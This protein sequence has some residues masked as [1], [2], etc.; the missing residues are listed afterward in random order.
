MKIQTFLLL[1]IAFVLSNCQSPNEPTA[2]GV[3]PSTPYPNPPAEGFNAEDSD[4]RAMEIADSVMLAM[5]GRQSWDTT[6]YFHWNFFGMRTLLWDKQEGRAK[7]TMLQDSTQMVV[8]LETGEGEIYREGNKLTDETALREGLQQ[9]KSIWIND[10]YWLFMPFKLK[11]SGVTLKYLKA[12]TTQAGQA[13]DVLQLTFESVGDTPQNKYHVWVGKEDRLVRQWAYFSN[14]TDE[15]PKFI[16]PW[17]D[18]QTYGDIMLSGDRG[19]RQ[20]TDIKVMEEVPR[21]AFAVN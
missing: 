15:E 17:D 2:A 10:A 5:G 18:Y 13:A 6:R 7:I 11:D 3:S 12:D 8:D 14:A 16:L 4:P 9:A 1:T 21:A 20:I 19:E